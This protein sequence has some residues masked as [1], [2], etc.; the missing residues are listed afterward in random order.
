MDRLVNSQ[1]GLNLV[2]ALARIMPDRIGNILARLVAGVITMRRRSRLVRAVR[3]NQW[4]VS[5]G[6]L[7]SKAL[8]QAT[9]EV[10]NH[11]A[12]AIYELY[13]HI[14]DLENVGHL[15]TIEPSFQAI[16]DRPHFDQRGLV[17][18]GLHMCGFDL[19]LQWLCLKYM[20]PLG[21]TIPNPQ[22]GRR[23]EFELR[24]KTLLKLVPGSYSGL[25]QAL[26]YLDQGG[27]VVTGIDRPI[28]EIQPSLNFFGHLAPLPTHHVFLALKAR[29]PVV[30][31]TSRLL[32]N[33]GYHL[34]ASDSIEMDPHPNR[35]V[36]LRKNAE[37]V[38][39]VAEK[40]IRQSPHQWLVSLPVWPDTMPLVP[41]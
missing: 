33:G 29:V 4:V 37:K 22:G 32:K 20:A 38:L 24:Q 31:V 15:F 28:P 18:A 36:E 11:S 9:R 23:T 40:M 8:D 41:D 30:L 2:L 27:L 13:H 26:R 12:R 17:A 3:A 1:I 25:R 10:F 6:N 16:I 34:F 5:G 7:G 21:L 39:R 35:E 19:A 14:Q